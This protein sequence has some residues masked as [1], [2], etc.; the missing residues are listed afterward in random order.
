MGLTVLA[1]DVANPANPT[2]WEPVEFLVD[3]G[4]VY[5]FVPRD[6]LSRLGGSALR[7]TLDSGFASPMVPRSSG[8]GGT[9]SFF[10]RISEG[11]RR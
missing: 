3:S 10:T 1:L 2:A 5:S 6:V 4:A 9:R 11:Q 7:P 8:T